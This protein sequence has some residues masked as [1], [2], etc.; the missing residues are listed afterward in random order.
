MICSFSLSAHTDFGSGDLPISANDYQ[1]LQNSPLGGSSYKMVHLPYALSSV[2]FFFNLEGVEEL[3]LDGCLLAKIFSRKIKKWN[4]AD[5]IKSNPSLADKDV[6]ITVCRRTY[7]SSST[8][9]ITKVRFFRKLPGFLFSTFITGIFFIANTLSL[10]YS[11]LTSNAQMCGKVNGSIKSLII[12]ILKQ[13]LL[14]E[15]EV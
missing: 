3:D 12:G 1:G 2:S 7:G 11:S 10:F 13:K 6:D 4:D 14:K 15:V 9:S 5:I 8:E